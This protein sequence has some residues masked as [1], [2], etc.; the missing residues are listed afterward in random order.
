MPFA[1]LW[2]NTFPTDTELANLIGANLRQ[3]RV[4]TQQ[5]MAAISGLSTAMPNFAADAQ[6]AS[7]NGV[8]FFATDN[9][10]VYQFNNPSWT[11]V[12]T[13]FFANSGLRFLGTGGI[14]F[15]AN[16]TLTAALLGNWGQFTAS[17]LTVTLPLLSATTVGQTFTFVPGVYAGTIAGQGSDQI[18]N[19]GVSSGTIPIGVGQGI[20]L[21]VNGSGSPA[22]PSGWVVVESGPAV[23][24]AAGGYFQLPGGLIVQWVKGASATPNNTSTYNQTVTWPIAFPNACFAALVST[25]VGTAANV[26]N[27]MFQTVGNPTL[28]GQQVNLQV[29]NSALAS[30]PVYPVLVAIGN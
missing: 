12:T 15:T 3:L 22:V 26:Y 11:D 6:P 14:A 21:A 30:T 10:H 5:R 7:W 28:T 25:Q 24:L 16:T 19:Q 20:R 2:D 4:D 8:L 1:N 9:G 29:L 23:S 18:S 13:S 17:S 27:C